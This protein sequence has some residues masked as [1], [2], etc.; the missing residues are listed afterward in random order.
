MHIVGPRGKDAHPSI[1]LGRNTNLQSQSCCIPA[2][3]SLS[4]GRLTQ[5]LELKTH[6]LRLLQERVQGSES[7]QFAERVAALEQQLQEAT[8]AQ[9]EARS[10]KDAMVAEAKARPKSLHCLIAALEVVATKNRRQRGDR[11]PSHLKGSST[12]QVRRWMGFACLEL[13]ATAREAHEEGVRVQ[14]D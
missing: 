4:C 14:I 1:I 11:L 10:R 2:Q 5:E 12:L 13:K 7:A 6:G 8:Q 9:A 3:F